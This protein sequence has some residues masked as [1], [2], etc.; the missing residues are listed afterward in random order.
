MSKELDNPVWFALSDVHRD[1][2]INHPEIKFY[3]PEYCPFGAIS[4]ASHVESFIEDYSSICDNFYIV[5]QLPGLPSSLQLKKELVCDQMIID[6]EIDLAIT[7]EIVL[8]G[9]KES[10]PLFDLVNLV[11]P[12]YFTQKTQLLG[13]YFGI[14]K[15]GMLVAVTG[16]RM[17]MESYTEVSAVVTH[18]EYTGRGFAKQLV[19]HTV[20][21][22]FNENKTPFLH[23]AESNVFAINLYKKLKFKRR[24][25]I[26]FWNIERSD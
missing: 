9:N 5:G 8:L 7:E 14:F 1:Y 11:Q 23:V 24:R 15:D 26:S 4:I 19:A 13:N 6:H 18:P 2:S 25:K 21:Q 12:G 3:K 20:N 16:E 17:K 10:G 22:I